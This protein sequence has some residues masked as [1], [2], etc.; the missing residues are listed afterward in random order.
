MARQSA[1]IGVLALPALLLVALAKVCG[2]GESSKGVT[3]DILPASAPEDP[4]TR[5]AKSAPHA[6]S[7]VVARDADGELA[8]DASGLYWISATGEASARRWGLRRRDSEGRETGVLAPQRAEL[9]RIALDEKFVY[10]SSDGRLMR[11]PKT[12]GGSTVVAA[13]HGRVLG[14]IVVDG[15]TIYWSEDNDL[16][17]MPRRGGRPSKLATA[18]DWVSSFAVDASK[19]Y[20]LDHESISPARIVSILQPGGSVETAISPDTY[21]GAAEGVGFDA[22]YIYWNEGKGFFR[23]PRAGSSTEKLSS[24]F[25][26][27]FVLHVDDTHVYALT[28][29]WDM[30]GPHPASISRFPKQGGCPETLAEMHKTPDIAF[31]A[32]HVYW[33]DVTS[34]EV[35]AITK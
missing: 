34:G 8:V 31:D 6:V 5:I 23:R 17:A 18:S 10:F 20:W 16:Y 27:E 32:R 29:S 12:G 30:K 33:R 22:E 21:Y 13:L 2:S 3:A 28:P 4:C 24:H 1:T 25:E 15:D 11:I 35:N 7:V 19:A 26:T 9:W 14:R